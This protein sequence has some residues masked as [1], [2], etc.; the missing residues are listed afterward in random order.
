MN[1][2]WLILRK[3]VADV[4]ENIKEL[5]A[6]AFSARVVPNWLPPEYAKERLRINV[7]I[8]Y[9]TDDS[10][11]EFADELRRLVGIRTQLRSEQAKMSLA[12]DITKVEETTPT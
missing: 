6:K 11:R 2:Q 10:I 1:L 12:L 4:D 3:K 8:D 9:L 5:S 7:P